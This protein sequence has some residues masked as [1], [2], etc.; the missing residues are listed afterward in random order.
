M[1]NNVTFTLPDQGK[2]RLFGKERSVI[3]NGMFIYDNCGRM[4]F[5]GANAR[6]GMINAVRRWARAR[7]E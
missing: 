4:V 1:A 7:G 2:Y 6:P 3:V 5:F